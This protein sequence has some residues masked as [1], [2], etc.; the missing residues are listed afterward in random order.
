M[1]IKIRASSLPALLGCPKMWMEKTSHDGDTLGGPEAQ[2]GNLVH[3]GMAAFHAS[4]AKTIQGR[5]TD[6][7]KAIKQSKLEHYV[8]GDLATAESLFHSWSS[9]EQK[10]SKGKVV[11]SEIELRYKWPVFYSAAEYQAY[12]KAK[13]VKPI[14]KK[15]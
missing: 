11:G 5:I 6:G 9:Q 13:K 12:V 8:G 15:K 14:P 10:A 2:T 7:V 4:K 3:C 1:A